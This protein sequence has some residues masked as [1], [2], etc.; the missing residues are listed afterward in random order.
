V[1]SHDLIQENEVAKHNRAVEVAQLPLP[2]AQRRALRR[3]ARLDREWFGQYRNQA[4]VCRMR[5]ALRGEDQALATISGL[6]QPE[7]ARG[8]IVLVIAVRIA[9]AA[10][11][12]KA[13]LWRGRLPPLDREDL[14]LSA[15]LSVGAVSLAGLEHK[16]AQTPH[17]VM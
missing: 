4:R 9:G 12:R 13:M 11:A 8:E 14:A 10:Y 5:E 2:R 6:P 16:A 17:R 3:G 15:L 1:S 7:P